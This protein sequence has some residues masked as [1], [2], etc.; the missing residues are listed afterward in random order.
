M[1]KF[2]GKSSKAILR[3]LRRAALEGII[4]GVPTEILGD[5]RVFQK[6][7]LKKLLEPKNF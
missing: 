2:Q 6:E 4:G 3:V 1:R 5:F 7:S